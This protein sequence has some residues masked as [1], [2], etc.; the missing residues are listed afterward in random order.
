MLNVTRTQ[1]WRLK[2]KLI[3]SD[4][5]TTS[6][7]QPSTAAILPSSS[8]NDSP[9]HCASP[10]RTAYQSRTTEWRAVQKAKTN[11]PQTPLKKARIITKLAMSPSCVKILT[12]SNVLMTP[13]AQG[14]LVMGD[15]V[16]NCLA[17][18]IQQAKPRGGVTAKQKLKYAALSSVTT[19][20]IKSGQKTQILKIL[21]LRKQSLARKK[22]WINKQRKRRKGRMAEEIRQGIQ[23]FYLL[24]TV[25]H[26]SPNKKDIVK[27]KNPDGTVTGVQKQIM[28]IKVAEALELYRELNSGVKV[29]MTTFRMLKPHNVRHMCETDRR[30]CLC[31]VCC[32][33]S[34]KSE[35]LQKF[36]VRE[37]CEDEQLLISKHESSGSTTS[38]VDQP[39]LTVLLFE[40]GYIKN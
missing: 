40:G 1:K 13:A 30:S 31:M 26:V 28:T 25:S 14:K 7:S 38:C 12:K 37:K 23:E 24:P 32:N 15:M 17:T 8:I 4:P 11:L 22:E 3:S 29:S 27:V 39:T 36:L 20:N 35:A 33:L 5:P 19:G 34:L 21:N 18:R 6:Q 10:S 2:V 16:M 9:D